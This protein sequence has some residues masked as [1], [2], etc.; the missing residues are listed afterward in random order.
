MDEW[1]EIE[2]EFVALDDGNDYG[3]PEEVGC[4]GCMLATITILLAIP[5]AMTF[6]VLAS[7]YMS[8]Q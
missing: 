4:C 1:G 5:F 2:E 6:V 3:D 7:V 8:I